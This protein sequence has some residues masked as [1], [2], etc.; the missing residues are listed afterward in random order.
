LRILKKH[1]VERILPRCK[2]PRR[3]GSKKR[4]RIHVSKGK[5]VPA[6]E[7]AFALEVG[8]ISDVVETGWLSYYQTQKIPAKNIPLMK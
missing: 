8:K 4:R 5:M 3:P 6:F 7:A 1:A 2:N